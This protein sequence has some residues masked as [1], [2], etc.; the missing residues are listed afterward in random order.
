[1]SLG[2]RFN[3]DDV[4]TSMSERVGLAVELLRGKAEQCTDC[5]L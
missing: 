3:D 1:M 5:T 4:D 2:G